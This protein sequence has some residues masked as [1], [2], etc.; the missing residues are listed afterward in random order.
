M[1][2]AKVVAV[3]SA[4][5]DSVDEI[6]KEDAYKLGKLIAQEGWVQKNGGGHTGLMGACTR[7]AL[8]LGGVVDCVI[9]DRFV[10]DSPPK[11]FR[12]VL[13]TKTMAERKAG[14]SEGADAFFALPGGLGTLDE[15]AEVMCMRQLSFHENPIVLVNTNGYYDSLLDFLS[16]GIKS[17]FLREEVLQAVH[18]ARSPEDAIHFVKS[19]RAIKIDKEA[20]NSG[21][22]TAACKGE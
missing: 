13:V 10:G 6:F 17:R 19:Y 12:T 21:E 15:L 3:Y 16:T 9:L 7:G 2:V 8:D 20:L 18:F 1:T 11:G 4:S 22:M 14:L 5:S